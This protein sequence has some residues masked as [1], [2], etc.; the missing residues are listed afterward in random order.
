MRLSRVTHTAYATKPPPKHLRSPRKWKLG[1]T[2][3]SVGKFPAS[4]TLI[5]D[6]RP[7]SLDRSMAW[8]I[9]GSSW[10]STGFLSVMLPV[11][12]KPPLLAF[13][14]Q[15]RGLRPR[16]ALTKSELLEPPTE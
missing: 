7:R 6:R 5:N 13:T 1:G 14:S 12:G 10:N 16:T 4:N 11:V 2:G 9:A 8:T 3:T 15:L